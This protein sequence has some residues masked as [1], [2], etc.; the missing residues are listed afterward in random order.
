MTGWHRGLFG[1]KMFSVEVQMVDPFAAVAD[2]ALLFAVADMEMSPR[3]RM[4]LE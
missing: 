2:R 3:W 1:S 4:T